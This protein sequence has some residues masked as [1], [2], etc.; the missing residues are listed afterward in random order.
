MSVTRQ[1]VTWKRVHGLSGG[2]LKADAYLY[3]FAAYRTANLA[4]QLMHSREGWTPGQMKLHEYCVDVRKGASS[5][6]PQGPR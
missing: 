6:R 1:Q 3:M 2:L 5:A 4:P